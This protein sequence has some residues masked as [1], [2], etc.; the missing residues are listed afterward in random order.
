MGLVCLKLT[1]VVVTKDKTSLGHIPLTAC[2][3]PAVMKMDSACSIQQAA[4]TPQVAGGHLHGA[5]EELY[6]FQFYLI[7]I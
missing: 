7:L 2:R 4:A 3:L 1:G 6:F 5:A